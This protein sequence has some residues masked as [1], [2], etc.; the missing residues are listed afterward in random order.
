M[1]QVTGLGTGATQPRSKI[2]GLL[3]I[4][5]CVKLLS[6]SFV[7]FCAWFYYEDFRPPDLS[8]IPHTVPQ[9]QHEISYI[10]L[11][12][13][14]LAAVAVTVNFL[15]VRRMG[16]ALDIDPS[17]TRK[18]SMWSALAQWLIVFSPM[19]VLSYNFWVLHTTFKL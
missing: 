6:I 19:V 15:I 14:G 13:A 11:W 12:C 2:I 16:P 4:D 9:L 7:W 5:M 10:S 1:E 18:S 3:L 17:L 8:G